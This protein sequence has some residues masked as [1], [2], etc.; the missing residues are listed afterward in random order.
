[1]QDPIGAFERIR[2]LYLSYLDTAFRIGNERI[3]Q[4][5]RMLLRRPGELCTEPLIEPIPR[6][7]EAEVD[8]QDMLNDNDESGPLAGFDAPAKRAFLDLALAGLFPSRLP[9]SEHEM[10]PLDRVPLFR[11]YF[12]QVEMLH[13]GIHP[14]SPGVVTSGTGSGKTESF[15]LP[16]LAKIAAEAVTWPAPGTAYLERRWW[17]DPT[18]KPYTKINKKT[19][20]TV[21]TFTAIPKN[22]REAEDQGEPD[23]EPATFRPDKNHATRSPF[24]SHRAG[25]TVGRPAAVRAI[26]L[27]P[28]N[29]LVEDQMVRLRKALDSCEARDVMDRHF[30]GNR[31]FFGRY[32]GETPVT[33]HHLHPGLEPLL[34]ASPKSLED[35]PAIYFPDHPQADADGWVAKID[36]R[37]GERKRRERKL[38]ELFEFMVDTE[39]TQR[40][41][42]IHAI[43]QNSLEK[44]RTSLDAVDGIDGAAFVDNALT[45]GSFSEETL[46]KEF[47]DRVRRHWTD[48]ERTRLSTC[49]ITESVEVSN[50]ASAHA[51]DTPFI[52][53]SAD[54]TELVS[55]WDMQEHPPDILVTNVSMLSA[56]LN[57]EVD[58]PIFDKTRA[59]LETDDSYFYI[60]LDELHLQRGA[61]GTEVAYLLRLLLHRLGLSEPGQRHKVRVLASSASLPADGEE[62]LDSAE[63][64]WDMFGEFGLPVGIDSEVARQAWLNAIVPGREIK[65][66]YSDYDPP[67]VDDPEAFEEFLRLGVPE[68]TPDPDQPLAKAAV[69]SRPCEPNL[70]QSWRRVAAV[71]GVDENGDLVDVVRACIRDVSSR[72]LW[73]CWE[74]SPLGSGGRTRATPV[75]ELAVRLFG[76]SAKDWTY[77]KSCLAIRALLFVRGAGDGLEDWLGKWDLAPPSFRVHTFFRSIEGLYAP[78]SRNTGS[79]PTA[80]TNDTAIGE[81]SIERDPRVEVNTAEGKQSLRSFELVYCEC[82]GELMIGG[83]KADLGTK[84]TG[85]LTELLPYEPHLDGLPD[86]S[87]SQRFED[88]SFDQ[89]GLFWPQE[90]TDDEIIPDPDDPGSWKPAALDRTTG[91]IKS[92]GT[93]PGKQLFEADAKADPRWVVGRYYQR[94]TQASGRHQRASRHA[95]TNVPFG[96]PKCGTSYSRRSKGFRLSPIRNFRAGFGKTTQILATELFDAQRLANPRAAPKLVSFSDSRQDAAK[97]ALSIERNHHQD[98]RRE[99][100]VLCLRRQL[101]CR[102]PTTEIDSDLCAAKSDLVRAAKEGGDNLTKLSAVVQKLQGEL[103]ESREVSVRLGSIVEEPALDTLTGVKKAVLP[104]IAEH[105]RKG[106]HPFD[107]AG[108]KTVKGAQG[109]EDTKRF[110]WTNL[111]V[112]QNGNVWWKDDDRYQTALE[113]A[114]EGLVSQV[115]SALTEVVFSKTYFSF[116]EAGQGFVTVEPSEL[117]DGARDEAH[118]LELSAVL[119]LLSDSYRYDP[120]PYRTEDDDYFK[121]WTT[122]A[123]TNQRLKSFA[124]AA[125]PTNPEARLTSTLDLL[126]HCG[127][128]HGIIQ[129]S[130][131]RL[132][133][134]D[135]DTPVLRCSRCQRIHLHSGTGVCTRCFARLPEL[136]NGPE[137][138]ETVESLFTRSFLARRVLRSLEQAG[139]DLVDDGSYRLH[140][141]ELTGQTEDGATRQREFKGIFVPRWEAVEPNEHAEGGSA[142]RTL[143]GIEKSFRARSE[144]DL[145]TVTTTMEV[146]IDIGPLQM[147]LQANM[148][149]QR[150]NYQQRVGRAGRRGQAFSMALTICRTRSHDLHYFRHPKRMTGDVPPTPFLTKELP[151]IARRLLFKG[152]LM[153]AFDRLRREVRSRGEVYPADLMSPPD[154][155]GEFLPSMFFP[156]ANGISW[157]DQVERCLAD[158]APEAIELERVL[159]AGS[160]IDLSQLLDSR[161][162]R[163]EME[164]VVLVMRESGLAHTLAERGL[165]PMYGMPTRVRN[166]YRGLRRKVGRDEWS[167]V[168]RDVDLAIY[169]FAPGSTVVIDKKEHLCVGMTPDLAPPMPARRDKSH[170][171]LKTFQDDPHGQRVWLLECGHCHAWKE[172]PT[173]P[174]AD[175]DAECN[176]CGKQLSP[177]GAQLCWVPN[178]FRTN[179]WPKPQQEDADSGVRHRSIHAEGKAL[180]LVPVEAPLG[181]G[182]LMKLN[183]AFDSL[184]RTYRLNR[185]PEHEDGKM[186]FDIRMGSQRIPRGART[187]ELPHQ[188]I[189]ADPT[190]E[191]SVRQFDAIGEIDRI[192]LAAPKTTDSLFLQ[193]TTCP[194]GVALHRLPSRSDS[195]DPPMDKVRWLGVRAAALSA[196]YLV[197]NR[198][199]LELDI[200]PEE[201]DVLEPRIYGG[202]AEQLPLLQITDHL[203]NGAGF[204][205]NLSDSSR[206]HP[207]IAD[208]IVSILGGCRSSSELLAEVANDVDRLAY[209]MDEFLA[210]GHEDCDTACYRCLLRYGNQPFHGILDWQ[211]GVAFLRTLVDPTFRCGLDG[212]FTFWGVERWSRHARRIAADMAGR[213][214]GEA[215]EFAGVPAFRVSFGKAMSPWVLVAHPLWDWDDE[216]ELSPGTI[217]ARAREEAMEHG[218]PLCWDTFN[219]SR[220][221]VRVREWIRAA[222]T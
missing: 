156:S 215:G 76:A 150:F 60:I 198:A 130:R 211:L 202:G 121:P 109:N 51:E 148:P 123:Q 133:L 185:G 182:A 143:R 12:H 99:L 27:Y 139:T 63:Y 149:P 3:A 36:V 67:V 159:L 62:A 71:L 8:F 16:V 146:G 206:G 170:Q 210:P 151:E 175:F 34:A 136:G 127:H 107:D 179:F 30:N 115:Y 103:T 192:W 169:E 21:V 176:A 64:L 84:K 180:E 172:C 9:V 20:D 95:G 38:A 201:F 157:A 83:L 129:V 205:R 11:P 181:N 177:E 69:V 119:R 65:G 166:L 171:V 117:P 46:Q 85:Y 222:S 160:E 55:R 78:I 155:H 108:Q 41:A 10:G 112:V 184:A 207:R 104:F 152:W 52:F 118:V 66:T 199:S 217:L 42:R 135:S 97:A 37:E 219:L 138:A 197:V 174:D 153:Q 162:L 61:S 68:T 80:E 98:L 24:Q 168:D 183:V 75:S 144:I 191:Q 105:V 70:E 147:I 173:E 89:Y 120:N 44:L 154:I 124:E 212:D 33:G 22:S 93:G 203:V 87:A 194:R 86:R 164:K 58:A 43:E 47:S 142:E 81:L 216:N 141:E 110:D 32:T 50:A 186:G 19:G 167:V 6:Y 221:Q 163:E 158:T 92:I 77:E 214:S 18:G 14:G 126:G 25:E 59:W 82:C 15:L 88:L 57:R 187:L 200:D 132:R 91:G 74:A 54:G 125:W 111:F 48:E 193:P 208:F 116:E 56:M 40:Q 213:F 79:P 178:G 5:R 218:N 106:V 26:V 102:R 45:A 13:R 188:A 7:Q 137:P 209:P 2:E 204:C 28:M 23:R 161:T 128:K 190:L 145:L 35:S 134:V 196:T 53:P 189:S 140:C 31:I 131:L 114:R 101:T 113:S 165:L 90:L 220:R 17:H 1:M 100:L 49:F 94:G 96:C 29:A 195:A 72:L 73:A 4:E 39:A 122:W